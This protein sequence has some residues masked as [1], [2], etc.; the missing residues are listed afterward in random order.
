MSRRLARSCV[1]C[2]ASS[3]FAA[4]GRLCCERRSGGRGS[5]EAVPARGRALSSSG[6]DSRARCRPTCPPG[7]AETRG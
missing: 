6:R 5:R 7:P 1:P 3:S 2:S 4:S